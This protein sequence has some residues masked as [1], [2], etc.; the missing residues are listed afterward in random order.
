MS[1]NRT[2]GS[3]HVT[4]AWVIFFLKWGHGGTL[5]SFREVSLASC[6]LEW[7]CF[8]GLEASQEPVENGSPKMLWPRLG[9]EAVTI[10]NLPLPTGPG[11]RHIHLH[12]RKCRG[13]CPTP[14]A[15][16][17]PDIACPHHLAW[18]PKPAPWGQAMASLR[19]QG[20][21]NTQNWLDHQRPACHR[22]RSPGVRGDQRWDWG[23]GRGRRVESPVR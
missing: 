4:R 20:Q 11:C 15:S 23:G 7:L 10:L 22:S 17:H 5:P 19:G 2:L 1:G 3:G 6:W 21:P 12:C 18:G 9:A 14:R 8:Y 16:H 13:P